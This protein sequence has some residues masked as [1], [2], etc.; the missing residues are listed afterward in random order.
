MRILLLGP[1]RKFYAYFTRA[2]VRIEPGTFR[3]EVLGVP[4]Q[5]IMVG[6]AR[7]GNRLYFT[8]TSRLWSF[9]VPG[10]P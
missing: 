3:H 9:R 6:I 8:T 5:N 10:L 4:P 2:I 1:D 7:S